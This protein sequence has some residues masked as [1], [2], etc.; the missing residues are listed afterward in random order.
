MMKDVR[1]PFLTRFFRA[2][3]EDIK[4]QNTAPPIIGCN[5][6]GKNGSDKNTEK[7]KNFGFERT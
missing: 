4:I 3:A 6:E 1:I 5:C 7:N 2:W